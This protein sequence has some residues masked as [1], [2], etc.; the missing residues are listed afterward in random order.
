MQPYRSPSRNWTK[1]PIAYVHLVDIESLASVSPFGTLSDLGFEVGLAILSLSNFGP[2]LSHSEQL[3]IEELLNSFADL[4]S[5]GP[6]DFG[7]MKGTTH[8]LQ[9]DQLTPIRA[10]PY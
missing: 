6:H 9:L 3:L 1:N 5:A 8:Q 7:L 4:F 10:A 2:G